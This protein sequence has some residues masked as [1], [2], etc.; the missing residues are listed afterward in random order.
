M[1]QFEARSV[2]GFVQQVA[3][4]YLLHG[5]FY[6]VRGRI[7][8][9]KDPKAVDEKLIARYGL[10]ISKF[11]RARRK[12]LG[13]AGVQYLRYRRFFV[14]M[15]TEGE[16]PFFSHEKAIQDIRET[17]LSCFGYRIGSYQNPNGKWHSSVRIGG[18][19]FLKLRRWF[20]NNAL[21]ED[22]REVGRKMRKL[23]FAPFAPVRSQ[24]I[25]ILRFVNRARK[26]AGLPLVPAGSVRRRRRAVHVFAF[27]QK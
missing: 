9:G 1:Y 5:Y 6:F 12:R 15:A 4:S 13:I 19:A 7:P 17:P 21:R 3:V 11:I 8:R 10:D 23:P 16:H 26:L 22:P 20:R 18:V 27:S 25:S 2:E 24:C 14:L